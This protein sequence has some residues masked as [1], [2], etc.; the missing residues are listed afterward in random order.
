M[1][2]S[3]PLKR[4]PVIRRSI[5]HSRNSSTTEEELKKSLQNNS[6]LGSTVKRRESLNSSESL[7]KELVDDAE[8]GE[9]LE[10]F[11]RRMVPK[12]KKPK[13]V[14]IVAPEIPNFM[15]P[16]TKISRTAAMK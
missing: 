15:K 6:A 9:V 8:G 11:S 3:D 14:K 12:L 1:L 4:K 2:F 16:L 10:H 5:N 13:P 7:P